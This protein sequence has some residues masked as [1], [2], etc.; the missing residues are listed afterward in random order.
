MS[1]GGWSLDEQMDSGEQD[2]QDEQRLCLLA[3]VLAL[4]IYGQ[5]GAMSTTEIII[6]VGLF[7]ASS[8]TGAMGWHVRRI[9]GRLDDQERQMS[10]A[11]SDR[12]AVEA[13]QDAQIEAAKVHASKACQGSRDSP[14]Q[15]PRRDSQEARPTPGAGKIKPP[16]F[17]QRWTSRA[18]DGD[19]TY[20]RAP[21]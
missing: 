10:V 1:G 20:P 18:K 14:R 2:E 16:G 17:V 9:V 11:C 15:A 7:V 3:A 19:P 6:A 21:S 12:A 13:R 8:A 4:I 5:G